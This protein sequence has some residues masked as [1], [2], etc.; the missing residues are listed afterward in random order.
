MTELKLYK[1]QQKFLE[2]VRAGTNKSLLAW[3]CG[4][5]KSIAGILWLKEGRDEDAL[6]VCPKQIKIKWKKDLDAWETKATILSKEEFKK[7]PLKKWSA[8]LADECDQLASPL[9][10]G[11]TSQLS[12]KMYELIREFKTPFLGLSATQIRSTSWN[13]HT[14][15]TFT[16]HYIDWKSW[17][18]TFFKLEHHPYLPRPAWLPKSNWRELIRPVLEQYADI[19][20]LK[21]CVGELPPVTHEKVKVKSDPFLPTEWEPTA[22]FFEEH[23]HEQKNKLSHILDIASGY[24]KVLVVAY[25]VEQVE[26]LSREL[27]KD[28]ETFMI[29]G[30]VKNQEDIIKKAQESD[31]CFIVIQASIGAGFDLDTFSCCIFASMSYAV[32][33]FVQMKA[34]LRRIH[35]LH[36]VAYHYLLAGRCDKQ[37]SHNVEKGKD[38]VPSE[39]NPNV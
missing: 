34:R 12:R 9:F 26:V 8:I 20:L 38:F 7:Y 32:R 25:Y 37:I 3:E 1:H 24:R 22:A 39:W 27:G 13:L 14:L 17:R 2:E 36:P 21:D 18:A 10:M 4:V 28:R 29:H 11:K 6:I 35:N 33:D 5:G 31:E 16:G 19:V 23:R 30:G 15:L